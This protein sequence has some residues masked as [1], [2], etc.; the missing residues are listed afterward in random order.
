MFNLQQAVD[1]WIDG[2]AEQHGFHASRGAPLLLA[3]KE[4]HHEPG[5]GNNRYPHF[6]SLY[7]SFYTLGR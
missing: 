6:T 4:H 7:N 1:R 2:A 5:Q 3:H